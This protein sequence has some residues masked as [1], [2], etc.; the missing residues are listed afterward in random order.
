M[1]NIM[2]HCILVVTLLYLSLFLV[3]CSTANEAGSEPSKSGASMS[4]QT[5]TQK[6]STVTINCYYEEPAGFSDK[7]AIKIERELKNDFVE[8]II[9]GKVKEFEYIEVEFDADKNEFLE[10]GLKAKYSSLDNKTVYIQ[11]NL[12]EG[13]PSEMIRWKSE[14]GK[15]YEYIIRDY[16]LVDKENMQQIFTME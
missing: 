12:P 16:G 4:S 7:N 15:E 2:K 5:A 6:K 1:K 13:I 11:T 8:V 10:K 14:K 9:Q 3:S